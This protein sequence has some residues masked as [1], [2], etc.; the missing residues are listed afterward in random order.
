MFV[1][2]RKHTNGHPRPV[3]GI[4]LFLYI[5]I[6]F[7]HHKKHVW[8]STPCYGGNFA[9]LYVDDVRTAQETHGLLRGRRA[10]PECIIVHLWWTHLRRECRHSRRLSDACP[11]VLNAVS[12]S[13]YVM[14][15]RLNGK[16]H[17]SSR[18]CTNPRCFPASCLGDQGKPRHPRA[19]YVVSCPTVE[20]G[21][22]RI[23]F[24]IVSCWVSSLGRIS[25]RFEQFRN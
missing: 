24:H 20:H 7:V 22:S 19:G 6:M 21:I 3:K 10:A 5:Q 2:H 14:Q 1:P 23:T 8:A 25:Y 4:A 11:D 13:G 18:L 12:S 17:E 9:F 16:G 15:W